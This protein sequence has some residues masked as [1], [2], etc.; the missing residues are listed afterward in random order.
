MQPHGIMR[1]GHVQLRVLDLDEAVHHYRDIVGL[2]ETA[3]DKR[4]RV[5]FKAWDEF[6]HHSVVLREAEEAGMDH[7]AFKVEDDACLDRIERSVKEFGL[8]VDHVAASEQLHTGRRVGFVCPTGHRIEF[9]AEKAQ[10]G[11]G[12]PTQNPDVWPD[13]LR[14]MAPVRLDH[15]LLYGDEIERNLELFTKVLG[16]RLTEQLLAKDGK[17]HLATFLS[18]SNKPH[19]IA[20]IHCPQKARLH[21]VSFYLDSWHEIGRAADIISKKNVSLDMGPT[22]HGLTRGATIYFF[23][24]SG[25]RNEVFSGLYLSY[26]DRPMI[27][28]TEDEIGKAIFYYERRLNDRFMSVTT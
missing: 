10:V 24:P 19:D 20:F 4:G 21:H 25:N 1:P 5:Y 27:T 17:T 26:P 23:D 2:E 28:W 18:I 16:F 3:R 22:R 7:V 14:G 12:L 13:G 8:Q 6:D 9:F 11:N 15:V